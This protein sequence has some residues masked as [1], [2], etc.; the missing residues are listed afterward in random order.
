[1][2]TLASFEFNTHSPFTDYFTPPITATLDTLRQITLTLPSFEPKIAMR[3]PNQ[4][5]K[6]ELLLFVYAT[7]FASN[8]PIAQAHLLLPIDKQTPIQPATTW[9]SPPLPDGFFILVCTK[10]M[11]YKSNPF[12]G[13]DYVNN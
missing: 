1:M 13:K 11:Y 9:T 3:F 4:T 2:D 7:N 5:D 6:A 8:N 12:T 10:I